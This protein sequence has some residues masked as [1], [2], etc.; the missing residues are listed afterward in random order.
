MTPSACPQCGGVN[1]RT[2]PDTLYPH[3]TRYGCPQCGGDFYWDGE[4]SLS[5][6]ELKDLERSWGEV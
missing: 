5:E 1:V 2:L 6:H 4:R 3:L